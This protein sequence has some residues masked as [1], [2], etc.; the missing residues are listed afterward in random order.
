MAELKV[1]ATVANEA[2]EGLVISRLAESGIKA[3]AQRTI[4]NVEFGGSGARNVLVEESQM[5]R[6]RELLAGDEAIDED[7]LARLSE[8]AGRDGPES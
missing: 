3:V 6:A 2:E 5:D 7:E 8:E 4:G 1:V